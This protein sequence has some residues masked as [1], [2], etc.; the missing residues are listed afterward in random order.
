ME[1]VAYST[2]RNGMKDYMRKTRDDAE[3]LLVVSRDSSE[4]IVVMSARDYDA[5][6]ET[7]RIYQN[8]PLH[9]KILRGI[10]QASEGAALPRDL[11]E[12]D[13]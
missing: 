4:N 1:A 6:M 9:E 10:R 5:L 3:A 7:F 11:I 13:D 8:R 12:D 2:F